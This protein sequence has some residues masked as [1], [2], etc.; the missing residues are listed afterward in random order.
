M[1]KLFLTLFL[2]IFLTLSLSSCFFGSKESERDLPYYKNL[3]KETFR[4]YQAAV[5]QIPK[6]GKFDFEVATMVSGSGQPLSEFGGMKFQ[7]KFSSLSIGFL[8]D[9]NFED[10]EHPS[11]DA[12]I[13]VY[14]N[15]RSFGAGD[16]DITFKITG[17]GSVSYSLNHLD[18]ATLEFLGAPKEMVDDLMLAYDENK[19]KLISSDARAE[20]LKEI[21]ATLALSQKNSPLRENSKEEEQKII[22]AFLETEVLEITA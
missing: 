16:I 19:G 22:D 1:K 14:L 17:D 11:I 12:T 8:G 2:S 3:W 5:T 18:R 20:F 7:D 15:K 21:F 9:Y 10:Q 6:K 4:S 13:K